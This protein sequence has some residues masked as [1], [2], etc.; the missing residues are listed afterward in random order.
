MGRNLNIISMLNHLSIWLQW[1]WECFLSSKGWWKLC[2]LVMR[3]RSTVCFIFVEQQPMFLHWNL[4]CIEIKILFLNLS[5]YHTLSHP[6][7]FSLGL[8]L[9]LFSL[10]TGSLS[11]YLTFFSSP[12]FLS[13]TSFH[14]FSLSLYL[15]IF[16]SLSHP[17]TNSCPCLNEFI[18]HMSSNDRAITIMSYWEPLY[19]LDYQ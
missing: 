1:L 16:L 2:R 7:S 5:N 11:L 15:S 14:T 19:S 9:S 18:L 8:S 12:L 13:L 17:P 10:F 3:S 6:F 4:L